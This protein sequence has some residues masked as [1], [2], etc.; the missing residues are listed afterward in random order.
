MHR[1]T[2]LD[3]GAAVGRLAD[4]ALGRAAALGAAHASFHLTRVRTARS[5]LRDA[6][7]Q[8]GMDTTDTA[9]SVRLIHRGAPGFATACVLT[10][11]TAAET[12]ERAVAMARACAVLST[13]AAEP[14]DEPV[15][16]DGE[17]TSAYRIDPFEVP[18]ADRV[19]LMAD[20]SGR[21]L[22]AAPVEHVLAFLTAVREDRFYA[23]LAGTVTT[24]RRIRLHPLLLAQGAD[25]RTGS[26]AMMRTLGPPSARGWEYMS[27]DGWDWDA[28]LAELPEL[29]AGKLRARPVEP[30]RYD[31]VVDASNLWLTIHESVG[32]ATELDRALGHEASYTGTSFA[33]PDRLGILRYGSPL[34]TVTADRTA[35]HGL[36]TTG[37]DDEGVAAQSWNLVEE[38]VLVGFQCDRRTARLAG[39]PRSNGCAWAESAAYAPI[40]RMAN[41]GLCP[42]PRGPGTGELIAGVEDGIYLVGSDSWSIDMRREHFQFTA[43]RCH[44]IR[45]GRL[46]GQLDGVAY[47]AATTEFWSALTALG[48]PHTYRLFGADLC[49]KG[50]PMQTGAAS[51]GCPT[52]VFQ[53]VRVLNTA[54]AAL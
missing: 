49:G 21:L 15:Y 45:N 20:M 41:V 28:E 29:L 22:S 46:D 3:L 14:V 4:A 5:L 42:A 6:A 19:A 44:R 17:W 31:L 7:P 40:Q 27:G 24:Q 52:A 30:G 51:H 53:G 37:F 11:E 12:A 8:D 39:A 33:T 48:G 38:G 10:A 47:E 13:S 23:D 54:D 9:L 18:E 43:Q 34:M 16:H 35:E 36:A 2:D 32:H 26:R 25:S 50:Q 1:S